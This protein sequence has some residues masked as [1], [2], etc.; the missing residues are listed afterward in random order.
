MNN[1]RLIGIVDDHT[2]FRKG[3]AAL[4]NL[5]PGY[6]VIFD[7]AGGSECLAL[8]KKG[9][10]PQVLL[11]DIAMPKPDGYEVTAWIKKNLP[12][13]AVLALSTMDNELSIIRMIKSGARGYILKDS[14][15][16]E[17]KTAFNEVLALGFYY[18]DQVSRK[19]IKSLHDFPVDEE[20]PGPLLGLTERE[21]QFLKHSCSEKTYSEIAKEMYVSERTIDGY[22]DALFRKLSIGSRVGLVLFALR[23]GIAQL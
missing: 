4:I 21:L 23:N 18:N 7:A 10:V 22:R 11:M 1:V 2:M 14:D 5:F 8:L 15:T 20:A 9:L 17:L 12:D 3:L 19:I 16:E 13:I 6:Q